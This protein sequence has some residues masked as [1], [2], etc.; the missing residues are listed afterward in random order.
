MA[1]HFVKPLNILIHNGANGIEGRLR[2]FADRRFWFDGVE[3][4][5]IESVLEAL[6]NAVVKSK[7]GSWNPEGTAL[8]KSEYI[9]H[10]LYFSDGSCSQEVQPSVRE[11]NDILIQPVLPIS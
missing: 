5:S 10:L 4:A 6:K 9:S 8:T 1:E 3:C 2:T 7:V 11:A